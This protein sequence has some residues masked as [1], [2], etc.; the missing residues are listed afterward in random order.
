MT[1]RW[2][3]DDQLIPACRAGGRSMADLDTPDRCWA[4][5]GMT[6]AGLTAETIADL[7]DC[8][9]RLVKSVRAEPMT[10]VCLLLMDETAAFEAETRLLRSE[11]R[12]TTRDVAAL[13]STAADLRAQLDRVIDARL[14]G[15]RVDVCSAGT[16]LMTEQ[17]TYRNQG[18]RWCR[19]CRRENQRRYRARSTQVITDQISGSDLDPGAPEV[20]DVV[21]PGSPVRRGAAD[22]GDVAA[23]G[24]VDL[25]VRGPAAG[26]HR[27]TGGLDAGEQ[28]P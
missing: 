16:H 19:A 28:H 20:G 8:S 13:T 9:L 1:E 7:L 26:L 15:E 3:P 5:A 22:R 14:T 24:V 21:A 27:S 23:L 2:E 6:R 25:P 12:A 10:A 4:V 17:N 18:R 11:L